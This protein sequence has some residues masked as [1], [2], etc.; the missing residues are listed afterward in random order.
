MKLRERSQGGGDARRSGGGAKPPVILEGSEEG[1]GQLPSPNTASHEASTLNPRS[2][3]SLSGLGMPKPQSSSGRY[4]SSQPPPRTFRH[5]S[6]LLSVI[7]TLS[8]AP[9]HFTGGEAVTDALGGLLRQDLRECFVHPLGS[10]EKESSEGVGATADGGEAATSSDGPRGEWLSSDDMKGVRK[11]LERLLDSNRWIEIE[12]EIDP[13]SS[14]QPLAR[15]ESR[16]AHAR[17]LFPYQESRVGAISAASPEREGDETVVLDPAPL[18]L[19]ATKRML[20]RR[21]SPSF[22][23]REEADAP[24]DELHQEED[25]HGHS[26]Q[27]EE[28]EDVEAEEDAR[29]DPEFSLAEIKS[30][31]SELFE[32]TT[33]PSPP[34]LPPAPAPSPFTPH[35]LT[36]LKE[37]STSDG[38][39]SQEDSPV[40][41][42]EVKLTDFFFENNNTPSPPPHALIASFLRPSTSMGP[43]SS[44]SDPYSSEAPP[45]APVAA[46]SVV[47]SLQILPK[48]SSARMAS[49]KVSKAATGVSSSASTRVGSK[50]LVV[51]TLSRASASFLH[52]NDASSSKSAI[53]PRP[54]PHQAKPNAKPAASSVTLAAPTASSLARLKEKQKGESS[55]GSNNPLFSSRFK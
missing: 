33:S 7:D 53:P 2:Q 48:S 41:S 16:G 11:D 36:R 3:I 29:V 28:E 24:H 51:S 46:S 9:A 47:P 12:I 39:E 52:N 21:L 37:V 1:S 20:S 49:S 8:Q 27:E 25:G 23:L 5:R 34:A 30:K 42:T 15:A 10:R 18:A 6:L 35:P 17:L 45:S 31:R 40:I 13:S 50:P 4:P 43:E 22:A 54:P 55:P 14:S 32:V 44:S 19:L 38:N 26:H